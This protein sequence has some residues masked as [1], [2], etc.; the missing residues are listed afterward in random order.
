MMSSFLTAR[1]KLF[2]QEKIIKKG[3]TKLI[4]PWKKK[5]NIRLSYLTKNPQILSFI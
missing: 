1:I 3:K 5:S 2:L 4:L